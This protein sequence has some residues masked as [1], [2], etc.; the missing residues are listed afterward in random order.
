MG[1]F[2]DNLNGNFVQKTEIAKNMSEVV[3]KAAKLCKI[4]SYHFKTSQDIDWSADQHLSS[5]SKFTQIRKSGLQI[6][7]RQ[8]QTK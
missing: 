7:N 1:L 6:I 5:G 2:L 4:L 3:L 8:C